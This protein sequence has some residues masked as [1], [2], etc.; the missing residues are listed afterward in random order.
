LEIVYITTIELNITTAVDGAYVYV[1]YSIRDAL[2][3]LQTHFGNPTGCGERTAA[4][5]VADEN[6]PSVPKAIHH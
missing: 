3:I 4:V 2:S 5:E 6:C 1:Q